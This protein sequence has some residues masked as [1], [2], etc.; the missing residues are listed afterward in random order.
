MDRQ[1]ADISFNRVQRRE[2]PED[3][4]SFEAFLRCK[5]AELLGTLNVNTLRDEDRAIELAHCRSLLGI[6]IL[7]I[8]EHRIIHEEPTEYRKIGNSTL[9]T[10]SGWRNEMQA[11]QGGAG[12]L[13]GQKARKALLKA[14]CC[15]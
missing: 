3:S 10:V 4:R 12:P 15:C 9:I 14:I 2:V 7:G 1:Y 13:L 11:S 6:E 5:R 8:Q